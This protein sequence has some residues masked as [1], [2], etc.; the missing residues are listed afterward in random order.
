MRNRQTEWEKRPRQR[1]TN[2]Y[3][4]C[5]ILGTKFYDALTPEQQFAAECYIEENLIIPGDTTYR[6]DLLTIIE[7][8]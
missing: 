5:T 8:S 7:R 4:A 1:R 6:N 2:E 3:I